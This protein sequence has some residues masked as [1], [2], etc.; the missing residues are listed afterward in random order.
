MI[1][2]YTYTNHYLHH[3]QSP[4]EVT[5]AATM[6]HAGSLSTPLGSSCA[7][8]NMAAGFPELNGGFTGSFPDSHVR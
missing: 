6:Q 4:Q 2:T 7:L 3:Q 1:Y 5:K 8:V